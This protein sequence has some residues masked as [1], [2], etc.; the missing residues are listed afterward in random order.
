DA[1]A[2]ALRASAAL[3]ALQGEELRIRREVADG[4]HGTV[5]QRFIL[6]GARLDALLPALDARE[7]ERAASAPDSD[8]G[9][10]LDSDS[11]PESA[12]APG[13]GGGD[14][15]E[16]RAIRAELD[17]LREQDLRAMSEL[18]Y[19]A[20]LDQ[21]AVPAIR[22][23]LARVPATIAV[24]FELSAGAADRESGGHR[25]LT[26]ERRLLLVRVVEEALSNALKHGRA[27]EV[28]LL[29][30]H[31]GGSAVAADGASGGT[32][33]VVFDDDG[34]GLV[35]EVAAPSQNGLA[36]LRGQLDLC[37]GTLELTPGPLGGARLRAT[38]P[39]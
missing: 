19:P 10:D 29:L 17:A 32:F 37:G 9:S 31:V 26:P 24:R 27:T 28:A 18:L 23:L 13:R 4:L 12:P 35:G 2:Q 6:L 39:A 8:S 5:Q 38:V 22:A 7:R 36:R 1:A 3:E 20:R 25:T 15:A 14:A 21:G 11:T 16:L 30:D 33:V 34:T